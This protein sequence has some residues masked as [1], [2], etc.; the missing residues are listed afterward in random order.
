M[1]RAGVV[2]TFLFG[3]TFTPEANR[4]TIRYGIIGTGM[5]GCEH[6]R[7]LVKMD[8]VSITAIADPNEKPRGWGVK[9]C[10][11][12]FEP[13]V[14]EDYRD[15]LDS[16]DID[17]VLVATPN[18]TH[19]DVMRDIFST[20]LHVMLEKP[21]C[22]T[23]R[24]CQEVHDA[25]MNHAGVVWV[26]LEYRYMAPIAALLDN[27]D[28]IG[29]IRM[30]AIREHRFPFLPKV[31][32]WNRFNRNTGG[33]LVEKCCHFF[34][35]MNLVMPGDPVRV[36]A[37]GGQ[38]VN[39]L[40]ESYDG[41]VP[42]ILDNAYVIVDYAEGRRAM[43][44]LCMFA[45]GSRHE[46]QLAVTGNIGKLETTVPGDELYVSNRESNDFK[47]IGIKPDPRVREQGFHHGASYLEHLGFID[48]IR[49]GK[50]AAVTV[51]D[52]L[53]SVAV[54]IAG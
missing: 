32:N 37:S 46:Q 48:A 20:D 12:R 36:M 6:I 50:P 25:A 31:D 28:A 43:L 14:Y 24:D 34:D 42:D 4:L 45:E 30:C 18:F 10:Q 23:L 39:H 13:R 27:L 22:T 15:L 11:G 26:A 44:D 47:T 1:A 5:M 40:D 35:L 54:G 51:K 8:D 16:D 21:M 33:T 52:G 41:E 3:L 7:N 9:A 53:M 29:D 19:A 49:Q 17:A 2:T 38:D